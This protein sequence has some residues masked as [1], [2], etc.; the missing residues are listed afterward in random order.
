LNWEEEIEREQAMGELL[1]GR[2]QK[3]RKARGLNM[4]KIR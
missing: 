2:E 1:K 4:P 3:G